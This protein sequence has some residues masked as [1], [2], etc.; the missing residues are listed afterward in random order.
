MLIE[1][2]HLPIGAR[3]FAKPYSESALVDAM[4]DMLAVSNVGRAAPPSAPGA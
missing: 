2:R 1:A 4:S 3:F